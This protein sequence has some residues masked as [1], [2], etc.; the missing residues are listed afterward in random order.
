MKPEPNTVVIPGEQLKIEVAISCHEDK[1]NIITDYCVWLMCDKPDAKDPK[2][3]IGC[4]NALEG[5]DIVYTPDCKIGE[6]S[7]VKFMVETHGTQKNGKVY[8][9]KLR[10]DKSPTRW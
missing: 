9:D 4:K 1:K 8:S 2:Y 7:S 10:V 6:C 5:K 3:P